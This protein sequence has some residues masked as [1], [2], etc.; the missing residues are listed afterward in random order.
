MPTVVPPWV[1]YACFATRGQGDNQPTIE[2]S[3]SM[4][5]EIRLFRKNGAT[6]TSRRRGD[7]HDTCQR[8]RVFCC[9]S[10]AFAGKRQ[11]E[12]PDKGGR[13][14]MLLRRGEGEKHACSSRM[15]LQHGGHA[16]VTITHV[17]GVFAMMTM[18]M[19]ILHKVGVPPST[20]IV[21]VR[22]FSP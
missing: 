16:S 10:A 5:V 4:L 9:H 21:Y 18:M 20:S 12:S 11:N 2:L 6:H 22:T 7:T 19:M 13:E 1:M 15:V 8:Q 14:K 3:L 17:V